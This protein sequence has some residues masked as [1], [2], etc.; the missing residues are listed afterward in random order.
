MVGFLIEIPPQGKKTIS[1]TYTSSIRFKPGKATYQL[2]LQKQI[3]AL[4]HDVHFSLQLPSDMN[5]LNTNFSP[6]VK[7]NLILYNTDLSTD[8]VFFIEL[9]K[10]HL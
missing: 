9:L 2:V 4:S 3:G 8:R 10:E 6:L 5:L 1:I 7:N